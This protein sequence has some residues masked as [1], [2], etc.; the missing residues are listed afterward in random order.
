M[1]RRGRRALLGLKL[2]EVKSVTTRSISDASTAQTAKPIK[3]VV[4]GGDVAVGIVAPSCTFLED[5]DVLS[6]HGIGVR[7]YDNWVQRGSGH[8]VV[9]F[10]RGDV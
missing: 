10:E 1:L 7:Y 3:H 2:L 6:L 4:P 5:N 8:R 9:T